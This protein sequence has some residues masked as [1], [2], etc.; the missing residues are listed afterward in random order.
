[1]SSYFDKLD[2]TVNEIN[3]SVAQEVGIYNAEMDGSQDHVDRQ[4][5]GEFLKQV[6]Q[7]EKGM[8]DTLMLF[9]GDWEVHQNTELCQQ[10]W[11]VI[12][13][14]QIRYDGGDFLG[15]KLGPCEAT[16]FALAC[17]KS[18]LISETHSLWHTIALQQ[19]EFRFGL[20]RD[21]PQAA[22]NARDRWVEEHYGKGGK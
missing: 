19:L 7:V 13:L 8:I 3:R 2:R 10:I 5:G 1:M 14:N 15:D 18:R 17:R 16:T 20:V 11:K 21:N 12:V 9:I 22:V 4:A 6:M